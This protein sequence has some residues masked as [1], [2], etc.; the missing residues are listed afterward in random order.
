MERSGKRIDKKGQGKKDHGTGT[1]QV[2]IFKI[3]LI[4]L[5]CL[6]TPAMISAKEQEKV[7]VLPFRIHSLEPL[8]YLKKGLQEMLS[9]RIAEKGFQVIDPDTVNKHPLAFLPTFE[10]ED[11][12]RVGKD[13]GAD[14]VV[15]GSLTQVGKKISLDLKLVNVNE[16][17]PPFSIFMVEDSIDRLTDATNRA[18]ASIVNQ[19][20]GVV[21]IESIEVEGNRRIESDAILAVIES[22]KGEDFDQD[23]L[24]KDLRAIYKMGYFNDVNIEVEDGAH[25]KKIIFRVDEKPSIGMISFE[26]NKKIKDDTLMEEIGIKRY[27][28]LD[29]SEVKQSINRLKEY[30]RQKG[31]Y[32]IKIEADILELPNNEVSLVYKIDEG[33]KISITHI[34]FEGNTVFDDDELKGIMETSEKGFFSWITKSG[35][36]DM[37]KL[38]FDIQKVISFYHNHGYIKAKAGEPKISIKDEKGLTIKIGIIEGEQYRVGDV[39]IKGDM[40]EPKEEI[41]EKVQ[42]NKEKYFNRE[43]IR[44]DILMLKELY[45]DEGYAYADVVP[46]TNENDK[47]HL[48]DITYDISKKKRVRFERINIT[49]NSVTRDKVIRRELEVVEGEYYN[50]T[51]LNKSTRNLHR[52]GFFDDVKIRNS[53]G[54]QDD[55]MLLDVEV[56]ER[57]TG[58]FSVG[59]GYS[60]FDKAIG[61]LQVSFNNFRGTGQRLAGQA[62]IGGR[63]TEFTVSFTEPWLL[64]KPLSTTVDLFNWETEYDTYTKDSTG[65]AI[66]FGFPL[67]IDEYTRGSVR[68]LYDN[69]EVTDI[70]QDNAAAVIKDMAGTNVTSSIS[71]GIERD[72]RNRLWDPSE[73][74]INSLTMEYAGGVFGGDSYFTKYTARSAWF[75]PMWWDTV[76][77]VEGRAGYIT[78]RS[79]GKL[80]IY[81]KFLLGGINSVRGYDYGTISPRD[82]AT[83][84]E[85]GGE[86]MW[87]YKLEYI[88]PLRKELGLKG[89]VF[90]DAGNVF[91]KEEDFELKARRS[92]GVGVRWY[93]PLGPLRLEYGWKLDQR[94]GETAGEYEF[95]IGGTF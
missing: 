77:M 31:Y 83:G 8:D 48:V 46:I 79:G 38:D 65:G 74:S 44:Q 6:M 43:V 78:Q 19:I 7:A 2:K 72:S 49:G 28:I 59:A 88:F 27:S 90:F 35:V 17:R 51:D 84:D 40:I 13:L 75:F 24:D 91:T 67:N 41:L 3:L 54:S 86:K 52:L 53:E 33:E 26:G 11:V 20:S 23:R 5:L 18:A 93:S 87:L 25:G 57:P 30:Y 1:G 9:A 95:S 34:E 15:S 10:K 73:G 62:S 16:V 85:I 94:P 21:Q 12:I 69:A 45:S 63:T 71:L 61:M 55:L 60:S 37:K 80:P 50:G 70:D 42:I 76:F 22:K 66:K 36:L 58:T 39:E 82:L 14:W 81:E 68:Y 56:Q 92:I 89:L 64:D 4:I 32:N 29:R 47:E